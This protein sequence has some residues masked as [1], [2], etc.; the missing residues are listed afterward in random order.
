MRCVAVSLALLLAVAAG[1]GGDDDEDE[2]AS[3][4]GVPWLLSSG[5]DVEGW[6]A[7]P[8]SATFTDET[9][10][11][12]TGCNR[13]TGPYTSDGDALE[14]GPRA[15][16]RMACAPPADAIERAYLAALEASGGVAPGR[17]GARAPRRRRCRAPP[18]R[19]RDAGRRL[20][21][22]RDPDR[23]RAREPARG[24]GDHG[25]LRRRPHAHRLGG[26]QHLP[27]DVHYRQRRHRDFPCGG[28]QEDAP[29]R[30]A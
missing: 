14:L 25:K 19:R 13:F 11:G 30:R 12:F 6:E 22:D 3:F 5:L 29:R 9:V 10:G 18:L 15:P 23:E 17:R 20:G 7:R 8:P 2:P 26:L 28:D 21:G 4:V 16:T 27:D 1:C 24:D